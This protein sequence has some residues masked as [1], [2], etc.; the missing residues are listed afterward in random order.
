MSEETENNSHGVA[1][2]Q[3][4]SYIERVERLTEEK[5]TIMEDIKEVFAEAKGSGFDIKTMKEVIRLRAKEDHVREEEE[6]VLD[7][8]MSALGMR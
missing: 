1:V 8:Y 2:A 4:R 3:L 6:A 5:K 7:T